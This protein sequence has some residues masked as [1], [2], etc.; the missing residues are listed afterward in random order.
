M[1]TATLIQATA[2]VESLQND[3]DALYVL[4]Q[5]AKS[6]AKQVKS[7]KD[8]IANKYGESAKN[9]DGTSIAHKGENHGV[10]VQLQS[11][12]GTVDLEKVMLAL[13]MTEEDFDKAY[14]GVDSARI[15]VTPKK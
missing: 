13:N 8:C 7:M 2:T 12:K 11:V 5:Q 14:R 9:A 3:I 15:V 1:T 6:L 4:D 10:L